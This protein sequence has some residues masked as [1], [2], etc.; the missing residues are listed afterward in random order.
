M[1]IYKAPNLIISPKRKGIQ[2][3]GGGAGALNDE[4]IYTHTHSLSPPS[5]LSP[6]SSPLPIQTYMYHCQL[7]MNELKRKKLHG[8][9]LAAG[10][11]CKHK[12][13]P[14]PY[15]KDSTVISS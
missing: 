5:L 2:K 8:R 10:I 6:S 3:G 11:A 12:I 15:L 7:G 14:T 13:W 4:S 1:N 9:P